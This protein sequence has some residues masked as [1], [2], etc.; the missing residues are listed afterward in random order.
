MQKYAEDAV[1]RHMPRLQAEFFNQ[2]TPERNPTAPF[3]DLD[4]SEIE[5][6]N[7]RWYETWRALEN[8]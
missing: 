1:A 2:N 4:K 6:L 8:S 5:K 3:L 7:E